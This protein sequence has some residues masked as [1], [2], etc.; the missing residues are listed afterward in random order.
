MFIQLSKVKIRIFTS[1]YSPHWVYSPWLP[2]HLWNQPSLQERSDY[3]RRLPCSLQSWALF[4]WNLPLTI[5][6]TK[7]EERQSFC[8]GNYMK[9]ILHREVTL[10]LTFS[11]NPS[12]D[13]PFSGSWRP[14]SSVSLVPGICALAVKGEKRMG[15]SR[16]FLPHSASESVLWLRWSPARPPRV[17]STA[18]MALVMFSPLGFG[19]SAPPGHQ[20]GDRPLPSHPGCRDSCTGWFLGYLTF[21]YWLFSSFIICVTNSLFSF[22]SA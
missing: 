15:E 22:P 16:V 18:I 14:P 8:T 19:D 3:C 20:F 11:F 9:G 2:K 1:Q 13:C 5:I 10:S 7:D 21:L 17:P 4:W 12:W 6:L